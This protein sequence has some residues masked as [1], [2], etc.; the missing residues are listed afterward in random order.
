MYCILW[1]LLLQLKITCLLN[2][3]NKINNKF[4]TTFLEHDVYLL[5]QSFLSLR[6]GLNKW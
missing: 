6:T 3:G 1:P 5:L 4:M 2:G